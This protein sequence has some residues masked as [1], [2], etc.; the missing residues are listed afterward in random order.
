MS[1]LPLSRRS[2]APLV[3]G[4]LTLAAVPAQAQ[5]GALRRAAE[6]RVEQKVDDKA[7]VAMLIDPT[8]D[9]TTLEITAERLD[10]YT[11]AMEQLKSQRAGNR[12]RYEAMQAQAN[13]I[14]DSAT[15][16][17]NDRERTAYEQSDQT[18]DRCR[19]D[20]S[21]ALDQQNERA[22]SEISAKMQ[23]NPMAAQNDPKVKAMMAIMQ[24]MAAAQ[25]TNDQAAVLRAQEKMVRAIGGAATDSASIDRAA[26]SKCG[27]RPRKP[28]SMVRTALL[29]ARADSVSRAANG[30]LASSG[31]VSGSAVGMTDVQARM[32]WERIA[33]WLTGMRKDAPITVTFSRSEYDLLVA[34]R[35]ALRKAFNGSE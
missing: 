19:S 29:R 7:Q 11:A 5:L 27:A 25:R 24:E 23:A 20:V 18:Y 32:F 4:L 1:A 28:A 34:R 30:L 16:S 31:G 17:E 6:R 26:V 21:R 3:L 2:I 13:A 12:Q 14:G 35:G 15:S 33:S 22:S 9:Q 10:R 8:F